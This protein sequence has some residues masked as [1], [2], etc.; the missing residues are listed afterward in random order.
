MKVNKLIS[1]VSITII[2]LCIFTIPEASAQYV[3]GSFESKVSGL[4]NALITQILPLLSIIGLFY[5]SALAMNGS[6]EAKGKI[7][8]IIACSVVGFLAPYII[9]W[10][11]SFA[12]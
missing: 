12:A 4:S 10:L 6:P 7:T 3:G 1:I 8:T 9:N 2:V 11:K 5:A